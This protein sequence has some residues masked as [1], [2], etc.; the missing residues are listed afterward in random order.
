MLQQGIASPVVMELL[1]SL[2][3]VQG[4]SYAPAIER[5]VR[6][7][8]RMS[9]VVFKHHIMLKE[10]FPG[11]LKTMTKRRVWAGTFT[12]YVIIHRVAPISSLVAENEERQFS[13]F[14]RITKTTANY[15]RPDHITSN[16]FVRFFFHQS[17]GSNIHQENKISE[18]AKLLPRE[19]TRISAALMLKHKRDAQTHCER[20]PDFL[21]RGYGTHWHMEEG[22]VVFHD[23][24]PPS[25]PA[26]P[27]LHHFRSMSIKGG[28]EYLKQEWEKCRQE[29]VAMPI[30]KVW[31]YDGQ[32]LENRVSIPWNESFE[33]T[34][35]RF[36]YLKE[37]TQDEEDTEEDEYMEK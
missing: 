18:V 21:R 3:E 9:N 6:N 33:F 20:V 22:D 28:H 34:V 4:L 24:T 11:P 16:L 15:A 35:Q 19:R 5:N 27:A 13:S 10:C 37:K 29:G 26:G 1:S 25:H 14:K 2:A 12:H 31:I 7:V 17:Q 30:C 36:S 23:S 8:Y 32:N